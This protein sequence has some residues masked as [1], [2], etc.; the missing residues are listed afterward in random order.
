MFAA[1]DL[2]KQFRKQLLPSTSLAMKTNQSQSYSIRSIDIAALLRTMLKR[3]SQKKLLPTSIKRN[4][5]TS[6][7]IQ[8]ERQG[9]ITQVDQIL[10]NSGISPN[11]R[12]IQMI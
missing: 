8:L 2:R 11:R 6:L 10:I 12:T 4:L 1:G 9:L 5:R 3:L 7:T